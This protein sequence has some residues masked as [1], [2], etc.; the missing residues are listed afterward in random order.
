MFIIILIASI[1]ASL[2]YCL[3]RKEVS[4]KKIM[5]VMILFLPIV[6]LP[7]VI[8]TKLF[9]GEDIKYVRY[10]DVLCAQAMTLALVIAIA[11]SFIM[12][13]IRRNNNEE[14]LF[15]M[16]KYRVIS[17]PAIRY[18]LIFISILLIGMYVIDGV[19]EPY[20]LWKAENI[21]IHN[22]NKKKLYW[23][24]ES[25]N[26]LKYPL[27]ETEGIKSEIGQVETE[28]TILVLG[29]SFIWGDGYSNANHIWW[30]QLEEKLIERGYPNC[31]IVAVGECGGSTEDQLRWL[32][33]TTLLEDISPDLI[34]LGYVTN[35]AQHEEIQGQIVEPS[36]KKAI[37]ITENYFINCVEVLF[38]NVTY[39]I[40]NQINAKSNQTM[41]HT[42][43]SGYPYEQWELE[44]V[45]GRYL[46]RYKNDVIQPLGK[47][48]K[49]TGIPMILVTTPTI[50]SE[51]YFNIRYKNV[52][53]LF[54]EAGIAVYNMLTE[55]VT[56][57]DNEVDKKNIYINLANSHPG[58][59]A[60][61]FY[62]EY[63]ADVLEKDYLHMLGSK[64]EIDINDRETIINDWFPWSLAPLHNNQG[65]V[66]FTYPSSEQREEFLYLPVEISYIKLN[67]NMPT[68]IT[69]MKVEGQFM[70]SAQIWVT[71]V[72]EQ[73][74]YD[75]QKLYEVGKIEGSKGI[76]SCDLKNVTSIC[77]HADINEGLSE[78][79]IIEFN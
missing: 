78:E 28:K 72:D 47:F 58:T 4:I 32:K 52:L 70:E 65:G 6:V 31:K 48:I 33:E 19:M 76:I 57:L 49:E 54:E 30:R 56:E 45:N 42:E 20:G 79:L 51:D 62:A 3:I 73:C 38:P 24:W 27:W 23:A 17:Y 53:P 67:L 63:V 14:S 11:I 66:T 55:Y 25:R 29:D 37:D 61:N 35:D 2:V 41:V 9:L 68:D 26:P 50:T 43:E 60:T 13:C 75:A 64:E 12:T 22:Q 46:E 36:Q 1:I 77:I 8:V 69:E 18:V 74:G 21:R 59:A 10:D 34:V 44:T 7:I 15:V 71:T 39:L 16:K 5:E 40:N